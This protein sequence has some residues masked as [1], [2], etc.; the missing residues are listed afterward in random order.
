MESRN[1]PSEQLLGLLVEEGAVNRMVADSVRNRLKDSWIPL[2]KILRQKGW[3][4]T[5]Q[6]AE[7]LRLQAENPSLRIGE[8]ALERGFCTPTQIEDALRTQ[9]ELSPHVLELVADAQG[10]VPDKLLRA[11]TRYARFLESRT[12]PVLREQ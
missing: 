7:L 5:A 4:T 8:I 2:G 1:A 3:L 10:L 6:I 12:P 11:M 9:R